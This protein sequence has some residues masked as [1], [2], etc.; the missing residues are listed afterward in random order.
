[1]SDEMVV[2]KMPYATQYSGIADLIDLSNMSTLIMYFAF[3]YFMS[4]VTYIH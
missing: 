4:C 1:M 2:A 3:S